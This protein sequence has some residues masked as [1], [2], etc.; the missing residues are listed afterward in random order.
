MPA[1]V[2]ESLPAMPDFAVGDCEAFC[3]LVRARPHLAVARFECEG[4]RSE[5]LE[6]FEFAATGEPEKTWLT[7]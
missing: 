2:C 6:V 7:L 4:V 1:S 5:P 3:F